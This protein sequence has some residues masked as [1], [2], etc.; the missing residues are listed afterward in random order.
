[1][2]QIKAELKTK[3]ENTANI[4][5]LSTAI[6]LDQNNYVAIRESFSW[7]KEDSQLVYIALLGTENDIYAAHNPDNIEINP[8]HLLGLENHAE[9]DGFLTY[10]TPVFYQGTNYGTLLIGYSLTETKAAI[11]SN[12]LTTIKISLGILVI[13]LLIALFFSHMIT[14]P[15]QQLKSLA[16]K[17][18]DGNF[19]FDIPVTSKDEVGILEQTFHDMIVNIRTSIESL[20]QSEEKYKKLSEE[21]TESNNMRELLLDIITHDIKNPA[22]VVYGCAEIL[23]S[24]NPH[25]ELPKLIYSGSRDLLLVIQNATTLA[26]ILTEEQVIFEEF[27]VVPVFENAIAGFKQH[28]AAMGMKTIV[29]KPDHLKIQAHTIIEEVFKN[30]ISNAIKYATD[31]KKI[32]ISL[33]Q[34]RT[35]MI[36]SVKD[37]GT[38]IP[39]ADRERIFSRRAQLAS[40]KGKGRGL[41]LAIVRRIAEFHHGQV[42]VEPNT[43][44][45]NIFYLSI[46]TV[47]PIIK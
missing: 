46:P 13:G 25:E 22:G 44:R 19:E 11:R 43:P 16:T 24:E 15:I 30:F 29:N 6:A 4:L 31:G 1:M 14:K 27:D 40:G 47:I 28:L 35:R 33:E 37:F 23:H 2:L 39:E 26:Q 45:G 36:F 3:V 34:I 42:W 12:T 32:E 7:A 17:V 18:S 38:T 9:H 20:R 21:M 10:K 5:A 8:G 41:G